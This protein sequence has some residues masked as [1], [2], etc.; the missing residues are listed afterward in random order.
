MG[1]VVIGNPA[2]SL[3]EPR[4][5]DRGFSLEDQMAEDVVER[6]K[7]GRFELPVQGEL[8]LAYYE[9]DGERVVLTHTEVPE[10]LSGRGIGSRLAKGVFDILQ[11]SGRKT[12][13]EC[14]FM[15]GY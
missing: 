12:I 10:A 14:P 6:P 3:R 7:K 9:L 2:L 4:D 13:A 15:A 5:E 11:A 1:A 8:A